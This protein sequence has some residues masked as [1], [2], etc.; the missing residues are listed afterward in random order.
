[1]KRSACRLAARALRLA[2][3]PVGIVALSLALVAD[4][5]DPYDTGNGGDGTL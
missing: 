1:M 5:L 2:S 3:I 4:A